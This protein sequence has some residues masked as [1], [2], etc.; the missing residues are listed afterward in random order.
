MAAA[1]ISIVT[2]WLNA[3]QLIQTYEPSVRGAQVI[4]IDNGS[5]P[6]V[7][8]ELSKMTDRLGGICVSNVENER[9]SV[10]NNQGLEYAKSDIVMFLNNDIRAPEGWLKDAAHDITRKV[11]AGPSRSIRVVDGKQ[12]PYIEGWCIAAHR[13][14]WVDLGGWNEKDYKGSYWE[15]NDLCFRAVQAGYELKETN[16]PVWHFNNF[17]SRNT[18]GAYDY[19]AHNQAVFE[20]KVRASF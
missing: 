17:T 8:Q 20:A 19:S 14:T 5:R 15:D 10:A 18:P 6:E 1:T 2:P 12:I 16:W 3:P 4:V 11:I 13:K 7:T 9:F